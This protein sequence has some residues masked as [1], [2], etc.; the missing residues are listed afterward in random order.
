MMRNE[1]SRPITDRYATKDLIHRIL[2]GQRA[3]YYYKTIAG[4]NEED[5][6]SRLR[7]SRR[8]KI[9]SDIF[10]STHGGISAIKAAE[11]PPV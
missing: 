8:L 3:A 5:T 6:C 1:Y 9:P 4:K 10:K 7:P 11:S 2:D